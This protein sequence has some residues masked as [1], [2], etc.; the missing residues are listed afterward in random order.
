LGRA[1]ARVSLGDLSKGVADADEVVKREL[2]DP[3]L[4]YGAARVYAQAA[5]KLQTEPGQAA[6]QAAIRLRYSHYQ[7]R[8][9]RLLQSALLLVPDDERPA[10]RE[11]ILKDKA[12]YQI[13]SR[14]GGANR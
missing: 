14:F 1:Y 3:R 6:S 11:K 4:L 13:R 10:W 12:L 2:K 8:A 5:A 7:E 9:V